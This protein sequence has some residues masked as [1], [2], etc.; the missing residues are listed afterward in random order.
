MP[1]NMH[2]RKSLRATVKPWPDIPAMRRR[3]R[4][5]AGLLS[6]VMRGSV[7]RGVSPTR[8]TRRYVVTGGT[9]SPG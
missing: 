2:W 7:G 1:V 4:F 3:R 5:R 6:A 9:R 8:R